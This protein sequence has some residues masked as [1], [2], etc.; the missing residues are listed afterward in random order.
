MSRAR[1]IAIL[2]GQK[3]H[4][5]HSVWRA[6]QP[7]THSLIL[8]SICKMRIMVNVSLEATFWLRIQRVSAIRFP[9]LCSKKRDNPQPILI[10]YFPLWLM[11]AFRL[12][13]AHSG[14]RQINFPLADTVWTH[15]T[16]S[17]GRKAGCKPS[18]ETLMDLDQTLNPLISCKITKSTANKELTAPFPG[19]GVI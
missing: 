12:H 19:L 3:F 6:R 14:R 2:S 18:P 13:L 17:H 8:F 10:S 16:F 7:W 9:V 4:S 11:L 1:G 5:S 15:S